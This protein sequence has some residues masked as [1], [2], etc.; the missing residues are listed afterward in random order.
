MVAKRLQCV[1]KGFC[2]SSRFH[3][4]IRF[5][6]CDTL[7]WKKRRFCIISPGDMRFRGATLRCETTGNSTIP[8][9]FTDSP[10]PAF[11]RPIWRMASESDHRQTEALDAIESVNEGTGL[12]CPKMNEHATNGS[13]FNRQGQSELVTGPRSS[14]PRSGWQKRGRQESYTRPTWFVATRLTYV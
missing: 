9:A 12:Q 6:Y 7:V 3:S 4:F 8:F 5:V 10:G 1:T 2:V 14:K 11:W 13:Q